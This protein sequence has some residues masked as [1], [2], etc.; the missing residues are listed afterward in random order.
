M[1]E[2]SVHHLVNLHYGKLAIAINKEELERIKISMGGWEEISKDSYHQ[3][4]TMYDAG[5]RDVISKV[6]ESLRT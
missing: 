4:K 1:E 2:P 5:R 3:F 6:T